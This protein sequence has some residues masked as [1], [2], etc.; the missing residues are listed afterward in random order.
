M[1]S[2]AGHGHPGAQGRARATGRIL[3]DG[4]EGVPAGSHQ[5]VHAGAVLDPAYGLLLAVA[6]QHLPHGRDA[7]LVHLVEQAPPGQLDDAAA[8]DA[9]RRDGVTR[10]GRPV[11]QHDVVAGAG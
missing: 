2:Y 1:T 10:E 4:V 5:V 3:Q 7:G 9:V 6:E 11:E 8:G